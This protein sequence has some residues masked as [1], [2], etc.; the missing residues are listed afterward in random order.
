MIFK[1]V[2]LL[3]AA[4]AIGEAANTKKSVPLVKTVDGKCL[5]TKVYYTLKGTHEAVCW[6]YSYFSRASYLSTKCASNAAKVRF[7]VE[8]ECTTNERVAANKSYYML[9]DFDGSENELACVR[10][11]HGH[12]IGLSKKFCK[13]SDDD[14]QFMLIPKG[15]K[16]YHLSNLEHGLQKHEHPYITVNGHGPLELQFEAVLP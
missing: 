7:C 13:A 2:I 3:L 9:S 6:K 14:A 1:P 12:G 5:D 11:Y 10:E 16:T 8:P 15:R 4:V